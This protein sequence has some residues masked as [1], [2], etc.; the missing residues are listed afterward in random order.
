[1]KELIDY[2]ANKLNI[3]NKE[4]LEKDILLHGLLQKLEKT[5]TLKK[6]T[7]LKGVLV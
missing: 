1:M 7:S 6:I 5:N 3:E 2:L 4:L